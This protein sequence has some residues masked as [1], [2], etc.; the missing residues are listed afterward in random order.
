[1]QTLSQLDVGDAHRVATAHLVLKC[2]TGTEDEI[3]EL[4]KSIEGVKE[5][6]RTIGEF[7]ILV[8]ME[9]DDSDS[10]RRLIRW[11]VAKNHK[12]QSVITLMCMRKSICAVINDEDSS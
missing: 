1:M 5:I 2:R 11:K 10:L 9:S 4:L 7:D 8:K 6:Q 3:I 12:I